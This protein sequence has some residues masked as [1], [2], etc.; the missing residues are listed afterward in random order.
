[1]KTLRIRRV[2]GEELEA[3]TYDGKT[4]IVLYN[5]TYE[6]DRGYGVLEEECGHESAEG[7]S[8]RE[9]EIRG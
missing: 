4:L 7:P 3:A 5:S 6:D 2:E 8:W 1:M 9:V